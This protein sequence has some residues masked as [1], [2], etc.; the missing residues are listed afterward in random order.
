MKLFPVNWVGASHSL[1][2]SKRIVRNPTRTK[3]WI[4]NVIEWVL[5]SFW[6]VVDERKELIN[7]VK[8]NPLSVG[9][10]ER[11]LR[12]YVRRV[13]ERG[14]RDTLENSISFEPIHRVIQW[15]LMAISTFQGL[16]A[17]VWLSQSTLQSTFVT[18][19][20]LITNGSGFD[21]FLSIELWAN[22]WKL[23]H[24]ARPMNVMDFA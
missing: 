17:P 21:V 12:C 22:F 10:I 23:G 5:I 4:K 7:L 20:C 9:L 16:P 19:S 13:T 6:S 3:V 14:G 15:Q 24:A 1:T 18:T 2:H 11:V 8:S